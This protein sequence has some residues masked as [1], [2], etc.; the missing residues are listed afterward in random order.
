VTE[1]SN[2]NPP[3][4]DDEL[5]A[6]CEQQIQ[7][8]FDRVWRLL[9]EK[10]ARSLFKKVLKRPRGA[11]E[12]SRDTEKDTEIMDYF[13]NRGNMITKVSWYNKIR[14][15]G[16]CVSP[17][18]ETAKF[19]H[20]NSPGVYGNSQEAIEKHIR[21]RLRNGQGTSKPD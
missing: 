18:V 2:S 8:V 6:M 9:G 11:P 3:N 17:V 10:E 19:F 4:Q 5:R 1:E 7:A 20:V 16:K 13:Y 15:N 21:R 14:I 12:G